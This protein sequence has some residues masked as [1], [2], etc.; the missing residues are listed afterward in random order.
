MMKVDLRKKIM[1]AEIRYTLTIRLDLKKNKTE[2]KDNSYTH[3]LGFYCVI[4]RQNIR[5]LNEGI[6]RVNTNSQKAP[7]MSIEKNQTI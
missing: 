3:K 7:C 2:L 5:V 1:I 6:N 4:V